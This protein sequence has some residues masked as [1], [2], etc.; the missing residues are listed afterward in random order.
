MNWLTSWRTAIRLASRETKRA[1][2][3]SSLI[4][5]MIA[6]PV[7]GL[8]F[9]AVAYDQFSLTTTE[10]ADRE[11]GTA[12]ATLRRAFTGPLTQS[13]DASWWNPASETQGAE[14]PDLTVLLPGARLIPNVSAYL[15][16]RNGQAVT[17]LEALGLDLADPIYRGRAE[18]VSGRAATA[19]NEVMVNAAAAQRL[20]V[21]QGDTITLTNGSAF[22]VV[23]E[24][25]QY[26]NLAALLNFAPAHL[27]G[28]QPSDGDEFLLVSPTPIT[29]DKVQQ[30]NQYGYLIRSR[31]VL[32]DPPPVDPTPFDNS[33]G[34]SP[35]EL[36]VG[37][38]IAGMGLL[39]VILLA[40]PAF[41]VGARRRQRQLALIAA[42]GGT[43]AHVRRAVLADG[44]VLGAIG[45]VVGIVLGILVALAGR[46]LLEER[47]FHSRAGGY[48]FF[49]I[50]LAIIAL[51]A[52]V[53]GLLGAVVPAFTVARQN[54]VQALTGRR[55]IV[56]SKKR[57]LLTG[58]V[59]IGG[60]GLIAAYAAVR[61]SANLILT[62]L[63]I[64]E[65]GAALCTPSLVGLISRLGRVLPLTQRIALRDAARNRASAAPAIAAVMAA[66][67]GTVAMG[68]YLDSSRQQ[69]MGTYQPSVP[70]GYAV[71]NFVNVDS[72]DRR[73]A[74][75]AEQAEIT[76]RQYL[77]V[78]AT[79]PLTAATCQPSDIKLPTD[80]GEKSGREADPGATPVP[81]ASDPSGPA[82]VPG[83][84]NIPAPTW[85]TMS[86]SPVIPPQNQCPFTQEGRWPQT[87]ADMKAARADHRCDGEGN[88]YGGSMLGGPSSP[89]ADGRDDTVA[90][91]T[92]AS[93][94][95]LRQANETLKDGGVIVGDDKFLFPD[96]TAALVASLN[97]DSYGTS[98]GTQTSFRA[99]AIDNGIAPYRVILSPAAA[100]KLHATPVTFAIVAATSS[101][102]SSAAED[103]ARGALQR[104]SPKAGFDLERGG[105][106]TTDKRL[107]VLAA[108]AV[109]VTIGAA[110][111]ATGLAASDGRAD[112]STLAAV[113]AT[114]RVRRFLS[115]SQSGVI[116]LLGG[117]LGALAGVG[118]AWAV[119]IG[120]NARYA[121][122]W[123]MPNPYPL[124]LPWLTLVGAVVVAPAIAMAGAGLLTRSRLPI[125]RRTG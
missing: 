28:Y 74:M 108:A 5:A 8:V 23:G 103:D 102:P 45:A 32:L 46:G 60:G 109:L 29:W 97:S 110:G 19:A 16:V 15:E 41:A 59:M 43:P 11:M 62:G 33:G 98:D 20:N 42:N 34:L 56:R 122:I 120:L 35:Q 115:L 9:A 92:G 124:G 31:A 104:L 26:S 64:A 44:I 82:V 78:R 121:D 39:E 13:P 10:K 123:P 17:S 105:E 54:V 50:A 100:A 58:L 119:L 106:D 96:G 27:P 94:D 80:T 57:W 2:G 4:V 79:A 118:A 86:A 75:T 76:L 114:P 1:K 3:R 25:E 66:V 101:M 116:S 71:V 89:I 111:I 6:V 72:P 7:L 125:E 88:G 53:T 91:L 87:P 47:L 65:L 112:L 99:F 117:I 40:G 113:G 77:P 12:A 83:G 73:P 67:A 81:S 85:C 93:G 84:T 22:R 107:W 63:V 30:L 49:P 70:V 51:L 21:G 95:Q 52:V 48:R 24:F 18:V 37:V 90:L 14:K 55:G 69:Q 36:G 38:I 68:V 61:V